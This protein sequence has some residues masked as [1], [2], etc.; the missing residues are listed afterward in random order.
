MV[1][2]A[3]R[4]PFFA[5]VLWA[6]T[7]GAAPRVAIIIDDL[8]Y[9]LDAGQRALA[10][11]GRVS[12]AVLPHTPSGTDLARRAAALGRDV[13]LHLPLQPAGSGE[14]TDPGAITLDMSRRQFR[15]VFDHDL[16]TVPQAIGINSHRGS[17]LTRH[18]GHM[19]WLMQELG[20]RG[21]LFV[22]SYTTH[23]SVALRIARENGIPAA[24][25][26]VFLDADRSPAAIAAE[27]L[28][29]QRLAREQGAAIGIAHPYPETLRF[30]ED[31]L[32]SIEADGIRLVG[33]AELLAPGGAAVIQ[34]D[35][36]N[37]DVA[38]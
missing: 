35:A 29:L 16:A 2:V 1:A 22:D 14:E 6:A 27:Y 21:L 8:G 7:A 4:I 12:Y 5:F 3:R 24:K 9:Q 18:P 32:P 33:I 26:D 10:L 37:E 38:P 11:P 30:L 25:R 23:H 20:D 34:A 36:T 28:R 15:V 31:V 17:L 19:G 13:L